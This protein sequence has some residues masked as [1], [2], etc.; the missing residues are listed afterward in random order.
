[1][2]GLGLVNYYR[3]VLLPDIA[4]EERLDYLKTARDHATEAMRVR[5]SLAWPGGISSDS[6]KSASVV[7]KTLML[8]NDLAA[9][10]HDTSGK[11]LA[12]PDAFDKLVREAGKE[13]EL[14]VAAL[15]ET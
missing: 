12:R 5:E 8:Q 13:H 14:L 15:E 3:A 9:R 2:N 11:S 6:L 7:A 10:M 1:V 4:V